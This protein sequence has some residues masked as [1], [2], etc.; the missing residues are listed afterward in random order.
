MPDDL[1]S[2]FLDKVEKKDGKWHWRAAVNTDGYPKMKDDG[3]LR[4]ASH[5]SLELAGREAP[6]AGKVVLHK[7]NDPLDVNP[8]NLSVST[9]KANLKQMRDQGRDRPRGVPQEPDVK[10]GSVRAP[11]PAPTLAA[12][13]IAKNAFKKTAFQ[14]FSDELQRLLAKS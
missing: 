14:A 5:V 6:P 1:K 12:N 8:G 13:K 7:N 11:L 2:R 9:Q 3:K 4:L 10:Q